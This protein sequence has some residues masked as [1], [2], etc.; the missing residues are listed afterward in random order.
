MLLFVPIIGTGTS[1]DPRR[2]K[3]ADQLNNWVAI[4]AGT[5]MLVHT[6]AIDAPAGVIAQGD[7]EVVRPGRGSH[8]AHIRAQ[9][10]AHQPDLVGQDIHLHLGN[11]D[12]EV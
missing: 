12:V 2:P 1:D 3:Y 10:E 6:G 4:D 11:E 8:S 5:H 9:I 7:V